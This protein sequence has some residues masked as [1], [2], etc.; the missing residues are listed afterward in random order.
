M[1]IGQISL[2]YRN[3]LKIDFLMLL[4]YVNVN[5]SSCSLDTFYFKSFK[6][7]CNTCFLTNIHKKLYC[8]TLLYSVYWIF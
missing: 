8:S 4:D 6:S 7:S 1:A 5:G 3:E 2:L